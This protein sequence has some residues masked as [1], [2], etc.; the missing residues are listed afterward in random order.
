MP[1]MST[2]R[3]GPSENN[4]DD[5][6]SPRCG[7]L[8]RLQPLDLLELVRHLHRLLSKVHLSVSSAYMALNLRQK[9]AGKP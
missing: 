2:I 6:T 3:S 4:R 8:R 9:K 5:F 1:Q 7:K